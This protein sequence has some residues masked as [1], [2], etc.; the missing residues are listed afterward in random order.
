MIGERVHSIATEA[1]RKLSTA[2][3]LFWSGILFL[4]AVALSAEL[5]A[6]IGG[7]HLVSVAVFM[8]IALMIVPRQLWLLALPLAAGFDAAYAVATWLKERAV[9]MPITWIDISSSAENPAIVEHSMGYGGSPMLL[10][11]VGAVVGLV[12]VAA[13][14]VRARGYVPGRR[15]ASAALKAVALA[16]VA[17]PALSATGR[18]VHRNASALF[19]GIPLELYGTDGQRHLER[20]LGP[21]EYLAF[22]RAARRGDMASL[23][24]SPSRPLPVAEVA[25]STALY[26]Q[27]S[28]TGPL[29]NI[30]IMHA[31]S[32][33][34]PNMIFRLQK[35]VPLPLWT[36]GPQTIALGA[37]RVNAIGGG[38]QITQFEVF[39][40]SD[41]RQY[42]YFGFYS[43]LMLAPWLKTSLPAYAARLGYRTIATYPVGP[44]WL[45]A[46][47]AFPA[48]GFQKTYFADD[49]H[50]RGDWSESDAEVVRRI[51]GLGA[52]NGG[53]KPTLLFISTLK[54]HGPHP[55]E[56]F[57]SRSDLISPLQGNA[58]FAVDCA[59]NEYLQRAYSTSQALQI[60]QARLKQL[61]EATGRPYVLLAYG[62]H[63]PWDF[64]DVY[65]IAGGVVD[66]HE[67]R[68][69][70]R[71]RRGNNQ[72]IT[73]YHLISSVPD[74]R[75]RNLGPAIPATLLPTILSAYMA[76]SNDELYLP[77]N[78][79][80]LRE[81]GDDHRRSDCR[82]G[83][84]IDAWIRGQ[85][86]R[87]GEFT[88]G[89]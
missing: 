34:D 51:L 85:I 30:V 49:Q 47:K 80:A 69:F 84:D 5:R 62:D 73:V 15:V 22:T 89:Q 2:D 53:Q 83:N 86:F 63:Q 71:F 31:E 36:A 21:L 33:F 70:T 9:G 37:L 74:I 4:A 48:Y 3:A 65:S 52:L 87:P 64:T 28:R 54:N 27:G 44:S 1:A 88:K 50:L 41:T 79:L 13:L 55:C 20:L 76:R 75:F 7:L 26:L 17:M 56:H 38:T 82:I 14:G 42:G 77:V 67:S 16:A 43:P 40:G 6:A 45:G 24:H 39:T 78:F 68:S 58:P 57:H 61:Q 35:P 29:P 81:C 11:A 59:L 12:M 19:P 8:L 10:A 72:N 32:T 18:D 46:G 60:V 25:R 23:D 66:P